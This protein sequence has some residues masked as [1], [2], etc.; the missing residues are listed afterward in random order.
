M[1]IT[2]FFLK[3][4]IVQKVKVVHPNRGQ[5]SINSDTKKGQKAF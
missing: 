1:T 5:V 4:N 2:Y 3:N